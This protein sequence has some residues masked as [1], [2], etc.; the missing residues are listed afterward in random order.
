MMNYEKIDLEL[1]K[2]CIWNLVLDLYDSVHRQ[3]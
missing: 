3:K 2:F 1:L